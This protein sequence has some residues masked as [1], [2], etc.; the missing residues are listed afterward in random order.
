MDLKYESRNV[1]GEGRSNRR[2]PRIS[3]YYL[4]QTQG[5]LRIAVGRVEVTLGEFDSE[6]TL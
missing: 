2:E 4:N 6:D 1:E 5:R 3:P